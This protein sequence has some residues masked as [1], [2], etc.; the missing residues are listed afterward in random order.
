VLQLTHVDAM[1]I[2]VVEAMA[3]GRP[4]AVTRIGDMPAWIEDGVSGF[5]C[6]RATPDLVAS[7]LETAWA[8]RGEWGHMGQAA[9]RA[10]AARFPASVERHFLDQLGL[11]PPGR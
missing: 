11:A 7:L 1:P 2:S 6:E 8:R 3:V 10:F 4:V 5:T 9:H